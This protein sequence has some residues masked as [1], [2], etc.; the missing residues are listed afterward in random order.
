MNGHETNR[1]VQQFLKIQFQVSSVHLPW[2]DGCIGCYKNRNSNSANI[3]E[4]FE[5]VTQ[6]LLLNDFKSLLIKS[7]PPNLSTIP[8]VKLSGNYMLQ[9]GVTGYPN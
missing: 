3:Q 5:F 2:L 1:R 4:L 7:L 9:V 6:Q 8:V